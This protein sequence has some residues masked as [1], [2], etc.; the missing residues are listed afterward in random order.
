M[1]MT[2]NIVALSVGLL[3]FLVNNLRNP[4]LHCKAAALH[5]V[6]LTLSAQ[7]G[8]PHIEAA[9]LSSPHTHATVSDAKM[10]SNAIKAQTFIT[11]S[12]AALEEMLHN[13]AS[14]N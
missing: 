7:I 6:L 1:C 13:D 10:S 3:P 12:L 5:L 9:H 4:R 2:P 11:R 14:G 8:P